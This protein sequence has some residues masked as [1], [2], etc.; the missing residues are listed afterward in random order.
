MK[1]IQNSLSFINDK[2]QFNINNIRSGLLV[3]SGESGS[4]KTY[5]FNKMREKAILDKNHNQVFI[6]I[7]NAHEYKSKI[8][9]RQLHNKVIFIDD[10][11]VIFKDENLRKII[12]ESD[13]QYVIIGKLLKKYAYDFKDF[14]IME[15]N[16]L[17]EF[18]LI[19]ISNPEKGIDLVVAR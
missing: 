13:N 16:K 17:N 11:D 8:L 19:Y 18:N 5:Y 14:A 7:F 3:L 12:K 15:E 2:V 4:G 6:N 10:A 9:N 1:L